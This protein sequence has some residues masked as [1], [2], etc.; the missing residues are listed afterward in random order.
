MKKLVSFF[1]VLLSCLLF[2]AALRAQS[3]GDLIIT[4]FM[5]DPAGTSDTDGE[6]VELYNT[7]SSDIDISGWAIKDTS[8]NNHT[9]DAANGLTI[10][11]AGG[12]LVLGKSDSL[13]NH[14]DYEVTSSFS[15][16]NTADQIVLEN[17]SGEVICRIDYTDGDKFGSGVAHE[18]NHVANHLSGVTNDSDYVAATDS[19]F[20]SDKGSPGAAGN[21]IITGSE[22]SLSSEMEMRIL[23][24]VGGYGDL[25]NIAGVSDSATDGFDPDFDM[26]EPAAPPQAHIQLYFLH[27]EWS[28]PSGENFTYDVRSASG[29]DSVAKSWAFEV[30][31]NVTGSDIQLQFQEFDIPAGYGL[32]LIDKELDSLV[33]LR[34][35]LIYEYT[36][37]ALRRFELAIGDLTPPSVALS[38][39]SGGET[40]YHS[41]SISIS[42]T[43]TDASDLRS[44]VLYYATASD[45]GNFVFIDEVLG[46]SSSYEW[47]VPKYLLGQVQIK[48]VTTDSMFNQ[49]EI[50]SDYFAIQGRYTF[51]AGWS[52]ISAPYLPNDNSINSVIGN[53]TSNYYYIY[54][55]DRSEGYIPFESMYNGKGY[56]LFT[57][58]TITV[59]MDGELVV[60]SAV[61]P[62]ALGWNMIGNALNEEVP[63]EKLYLKRDGNIYDFLAA[64]D[65]GW[66]S[67]SFYAFSAGDLGYTNPD[68]LAPWLGYWCAALDSN[69]A[70]IFR[71]S[72]KEESGSTP[73]NFAVATESGWQKT[74]Y[75]KSGED[76]DMISVFGVHPNASDDFDARHDAPEP[77][78][79]P[80]S[81]NAI[82]LYFTHENWNSLLG[83]KY[84]KD[85]RSPLAVGETKTW[86][87][88]IAQEGDIQLAWDEISMD[89]Y[90]FILR[91]LVD[92]SSID[93]ATKNSYRYVSGEA[94]RSF[95]IAV[96]KLEA[97]EEKDA[98]PSQYEL[99]QN[100]PNPFNPSTTIAFTMKKASQATLQIYDLLGR[101]VFRKQINAVQGLNAFQFN[102]A[103]LSSGVYFYQL[104]TDGFSDTKKMM[105]LK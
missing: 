86:Q 93:M 82:S 80:S 102:A 53:Y 97:V 35:T 65:S 33:N 72:S 67:A 44:H 3:P 69:L 84:N 19:L 90:E 56:W 34:D 52:L 6:Y 32:R 31:T 99:Q 79:T 22:A 36:N 43:A 91:D 59:S 5:A 81:K 39:P 74:L 54:D 60:D 7:T 4:E 47:A 50:V 77:P 68:T 30:S 9:I 94:L 88:S 45:S 11:P 55:Y 58:D 26:P 76:A 78:A 10:V 18:L 29:L 64:A 103:G 27:P 73:L 100:Y 40:F 12:F 16:G 92:S 104:R 23:A 28:H 66:V 24:T 21:T 105:L 8:S 13:Y 89:D 42:W 1:G 2:S 17:G 87:F 101:V 98:V 48:L 37:D 75:V 61:V 71:A 96:T 83:S 70:L 46:T 57:P 51:N 49:Q 41:D 95:E 63:S 85:I 20:G 25:H 15:L 38:Y 62:L 14:R